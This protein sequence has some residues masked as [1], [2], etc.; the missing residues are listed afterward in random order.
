MRNGP[1]DRNIAPISVDEN[2][3]SL[4]K[5]CVARIA[6]L[7]IDGDRSRNFLNPPGAGTVIRRIDGSETMLAAYFEDCGAVFIG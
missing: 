4:S 1:S 7:E 5:A 6:S 3:V 2:Q